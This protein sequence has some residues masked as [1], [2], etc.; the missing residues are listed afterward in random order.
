MINDTIYLQGMIG[1]VRI[2]GNTSWSGG[3]L[4]DC[5]HNW[6]L[7]ITQ[8]MLKIKYFF[9]FRLFEVFDYPLRNN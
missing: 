9:I 1:A 7:L 6:I 5:K 4:F 2:T 8:R 3:D